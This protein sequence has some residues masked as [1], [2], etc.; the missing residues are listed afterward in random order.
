MQE[1]V[2]LVVVTYTV[3]VKSAAEPTNGFDV[4]Y[5]EGTAT[6]EI[7]DIQV[8]DVPAISCKLANVMFTIEYDEVFKD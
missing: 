6:C 7:M 5:N 4:P 2:S 3:E 1:I 8:T